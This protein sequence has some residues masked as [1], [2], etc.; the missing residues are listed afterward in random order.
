MFD[1]TERVN[2]VTTGGQSTSDAKHAVRLVLGDDYEVHMTTTQGRYM[3]AWLKGKGA[4]VFIVYRID[5]E[6]NAVNVVKLGEV[7]SCR[8]QDGIQE[9]GHSTAVSH[10]HNWLH[11]AKPTAK[12]RSQML[13]CAVWAGMLGA[14]C[15]LP[16]SV[17]AVLF[18]AASMIA[19]PLSARQ[20]AVLVVLG[21][22][23]D[24]LRMPSYSSSL[25]GPGDFLAL[26]PSTYTKSLTVVGARSVARYRPSM[27]A[28]MVEGV[29][30][31][32]EE[33]LF[34]VA[35]VKWDS[36]LEILDFIWYQ[37]RLAWVILRSDGKTWRPV[38]PL[39]AA[40]V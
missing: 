5:Q 17:S 3:A 7:V 38:R 6:I 32:P 33:L 19:S 39:V 28:F 22:A 30:A 18:A 20:M 16:W 26:P 15:V 27:V 29:D 1:L 2:M 36:F 10:M 8:Y 31:S 34:M 14:I 37:I 35:C 9:S 4:D 11:R 23:M 13:R 40:V 25:V 12:P 21:L 24:Y